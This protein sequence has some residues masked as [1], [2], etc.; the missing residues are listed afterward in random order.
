LRAN[1]DAGSHLYRRMEL[2]PLRGFMFRFV[3]STTVQG[4]QSLD[5]R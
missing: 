5:R 4:W 2:A 3:P 1:G